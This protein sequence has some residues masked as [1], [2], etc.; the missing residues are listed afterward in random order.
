MSLHNQPQL[1]RSVKNAPMS[2]LAL[3]PGAASGDAAS[4]LVLSVFYAVNSGANPNYCRARNASTLY[5][6]RPWRCSVVKS[7][8]VMPF[9][10]VL[11]RTPR[12]RTRFLPLL[13][14]CNAS[15]SQGW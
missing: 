5:T 2:I 13:V 9:A 10:S 11:Y 1:V 15:V 7:I 6:L 4:K 8:F 3:N 14:A 12:S